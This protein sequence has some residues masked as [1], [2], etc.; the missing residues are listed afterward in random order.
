MIIYIDSD[1]VCHLENADGRTAVET[2]LFNGKCQKYIEGFRY[3]PEG[4]IWTRSDG[5]AFHGM[6]VSPIID[7]R[8]LLVAQAQYEEDKSQM[9]DMQ[10][11]LEILGVNP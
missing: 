9:E 3:V 8:F 11:A 10:N 1:F 4:K 5:V 6:M 2:D 7:S